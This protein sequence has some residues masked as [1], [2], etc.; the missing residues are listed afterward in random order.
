MP[1][2][3][4]QLNISNMHFNLD[5]FKPG[6]RLA[7]LGQHLVVNDLNCSDFE[8]DCRFCTSADIVK[9]KIMYIVISGSPQFMK[10][11]VV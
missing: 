4:F 6:H 5:Y 2:S 9:G 8:S 1:I 11:C 7:M 3:C 10:T